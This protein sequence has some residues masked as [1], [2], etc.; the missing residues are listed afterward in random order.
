[1]VGLTEQ[2]TEMLK[3]SQVVGLH[4][5][6]IA[7]ALNRTV[8]G[9]GRQNYGRILRRDGPTRTVN[10]GQAC[11]YG[12]VP[13]CENRTVYGLNTGGNVSDKRSVSIQNAPSS[14][15]KAASPQAALL[16]SLKVVPG[17]SPVNTYTGFATRIRCLPVPY[18]YRMDSSADP[19]R[20]FKVEL[21]GVSESR[22]EVVDG[23]SEDPGP[24]APLRVT[25]HIVMCGGGTTKQTRLWPKVLDSDS[26]S[27]SELQSSLSGRMFKYVYFREVWD[28]DC[29]CCLSIVRFEGLKSRACDCVLAF[30]S[31]GLVVQML[32]DEPL[33]FPPS[34]YHSPAPNRQLDLAM[35]L[36]EAQ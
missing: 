26:E 27:V 18:P 6:A 19:S 35:L 17:S 15:F 22:D 13:Y 23:D 1:M 8:Y 20:S 34:V 36:R 21:D 2:Y 16:G 24:T 9:Y 11:Q 31:Y 5:R 4:L 33:V 32:P 30:L 29:R 25:H 12:T 10:R 28:S 7:R 14:K 3:Q